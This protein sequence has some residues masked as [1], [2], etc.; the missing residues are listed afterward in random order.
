M[1]EQAAEGWGITS[2][3][4][5]GE[6]NYQLY[7]SDST[8]NM[9][10]LNG[11]DMTV[12]GGFTVHDQSGEPRDQVNEIQYVNGSIYGNIWYDDVIVKINP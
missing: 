3:E 8:E 10:I 9:L 2:V 1:P 6:G 5:E 12:E 7:M 11:D 4:T